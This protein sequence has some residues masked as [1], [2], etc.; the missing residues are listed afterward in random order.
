[1]GQECDEMKKQ[2]KLSI[3]LG[4]FT[5]CVLLKSF[6][7]GTA[8]K[9]AI[10]TNNISV[11]AGRTVVNTINLG[12]YLGMENAAPVM[13]DLPP[14]V[15]EAVAV[16]LQSQEEFSAL[17]LPDNVTYDVNVIPFEYVSPVIAETSSGFGYRMHPLENTTKFHY[18][19]DFAA[20]SGDDILCFAEGIVPVVDED[21]GYGK[22]IRIEHKDGYESLYAHCSKVYVSTGQYVQA[23]EKI[24]LVGAT[25]QVT[26]P[27]L[28]FELTHNGVYTNPEFY[29]AAI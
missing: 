17:S 19:T 10:P 5:I 12:E 21:D 11:P 6:F 23:G 27:H 13:A 1:M 8:D 7:P 15:E 22:H 28:H 4:T 25:G 29:L 9:D 3:A 16:F 26:G 20:D 18:G 2:V 24:A 14:A